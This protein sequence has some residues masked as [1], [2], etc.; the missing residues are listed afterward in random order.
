MSGWSR[1]ITLMRRLCG[2]LV[3]WFIWC[4]LRLFMSVEKFFIPNRLLLA[5][6]ISFCCRARRV[7]LG[8][9]KNIHPWRSNDQ[10][11]FMAWLVYGLCHF[12]HSLHSQRYAV[13]FPV[14]LNNFYPD[15][16][17]QFDFLCWVGHVMVC[18]L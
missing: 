1:P 16:L 13:T 3:V 10:F 8:K 17:V 9:A 11:W 18:K 14:H 4:W 15:V 5:N 2:C 6:V 7:K 12:L